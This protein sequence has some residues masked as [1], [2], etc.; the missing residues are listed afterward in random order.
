MTQ[1]TL[2]LRSLDIPAMHKFG[3]GFDSMLDELL[4]ITATQNN[5]NYPPYNIIKFS[6]D[7]FAIELAIA[8]F[9]EGEIDVEVE[10]HVLQIKGNK[11]RD[12]DNPKE[13]LYQGISA[14]N[15]QRE[16]TLADHVK[17]KDASNENGILTIHLER[18]IPE[19]M[20]PK[21]IAIKYTK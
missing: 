14:R 16:F 6:E 19:E 18:V 10:G 21:K 4:R 20:K 1:G 8:G 9:S 5:T 13:Y 15:F 17:V 11:A 3:I 2:T 12:L 7:M